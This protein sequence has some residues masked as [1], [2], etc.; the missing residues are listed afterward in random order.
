MDRLLEMPWTDIPQSLCHG[1]MT[2]ENML[3]RQD[4]SLVFLDLPPRY[5]AWVV[6]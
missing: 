1:D 3:L 4:D 5:L 6:T 2:L